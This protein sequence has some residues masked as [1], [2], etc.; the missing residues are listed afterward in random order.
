MIIRNGVDMFPTQQFKDKTILV[1]ITGGIAAYKTLELIR[2]LVTNRADVR[3]I[4]T[5][6]A[7]KFV[8]RTTLETLSGNP[9]GMEMFPEKEFSG[10][11][12]IHLAD[13]TDAAII[14][15]A[16]YNF[17]GK[18][19]AGI[20]DDLLTTTVA[21]LNCPVVIAPAMNVHMWNNPLLQRNLDTLQSL[22]YLICPP[23]EGFLAEGYRGKGR[24]ARLEHLLQFLYR[25]VHPAP[26]SLE[27]KT[28]LITAGRT[29]EPIDPVRFLS[30][31]SSGKMG[32]ALAWEAFAR[33]ARVILIHGPGELPEQAEI[34]SVAVQSAA[35]MFEAVKAHLHQTDIYVSAAAIADYTPKSF[36]SQK[37]KKQKG[38]W[39]LPLKRTT[40]ILKYVGEQK[41]A[42]QLLVGFAVETKE[43]E[44][45]ARKKLREKNLDLV[46]LNNPLEEGAGFRSDTNRV[47]LFHRKGKSEELS[48]LSKLD[49]A[50]RI[51]EFLLSQED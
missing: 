46:V 22:G 20:A 47:T 29:E 5:R 24:L 7:E 17:I 16:T 12:H 23:E 10:T 42:N 6:A 45:E 4:M 41:T 28:V 3:V 11:H 25:A 8:T 40:D 34:T 31:R 19:Y 33:G 26:H 21:A 39:N 35:E 51:F 44:A 14:A 48:L 15:P 43:G 36:S 2:Y 37:I 9:V 27:G 49:T 13:Q 18:I 30:N 50:R 38:E 32:F 1:G